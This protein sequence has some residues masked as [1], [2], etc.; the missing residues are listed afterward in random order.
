MAED[1]QTT[2]G[3]VALIVGASGIIGNNLARHLLDR[4]WTVYGLARRPPIDIPGLQ[5]VAAD[6][7]KPDSLRDALAGLH[8]THVFLT[9]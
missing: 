7:L 1:T 6:L 5:P 2:A 8:P 4:E 9:H 3:S